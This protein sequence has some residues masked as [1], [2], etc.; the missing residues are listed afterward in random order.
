LRQAAAARIG[1]L[2]TPQ[3][4]TRHRSS[5]WAAEGPLGLSSWSGVHC[6]TCFTPSAAHLRGGAALPSSNPL[7]PQLTGG[8]D[9]SWVDV[10]PMPSPRIMG[11]ALILCDGTIGY[12]GGS[13]KGIAV[14][15]HLKPAPLPM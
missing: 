3:P 4:Q 15:G 9:A 2:S 6:A 8:T 5:R 7:P 12:F 13:T 14:S 10:G 11:D 1:P